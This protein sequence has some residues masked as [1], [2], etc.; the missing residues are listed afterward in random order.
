MP[1]LPG[2]LGALSFRESA[3]LLL[4]LSIA[5]LLVMA[6]AFGLYAVVLRVRNELRERRWRRLEA[7]WEEP[8]LA[9]LADP[10]RIGRAQEAVEDRYRLHFVRFVLSY[11]R[12]VRG[13]ERETLR[14][15]VAP[16]L[17]P[18]AERVWSKHQEIRT[19]AVQTLGTLGLPQYAGEVVTALD[20]PSP[21][22]AMVAARA[23]ASDEHPE[24]AEAVLRRLR[25]F[26]TWSRSFLA[27][28]LAGIGNEGAPAIRA[29]LTD[30]NEPAWVRAVAA[31]ALGALKDF[32]A[33]DPAAHVVEAEEDPE[34]LSAALRLLALVGSPEHATVVRS[35][36]ASPDPTVRSAALRALGTLGDEEDANRLL[37]AM[38]DP[39]PWVAIHAAR[40]LLAAGAH[41]LL[42]DL[43]DSDHPRALLAQQIV[44]EEGEA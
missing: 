4:A 25:R 44:M 18:I 37:G 41:Q 27:S 34:L 1:D 6:V 16:Y 9:A 38:A 23:L 14:K 13:Q 20:D 36:C 31:E 17:D 30:R 40:G 10:D 7:T 43:A 35:R 3:L 22:V 15:L 39:S 28:M 19:R 29:T 32:E 21:L 24:Y 2:H 26:D 8:V 12:R 11:A 5:A 33:G 42:S